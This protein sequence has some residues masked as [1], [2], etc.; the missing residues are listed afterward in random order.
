MRP[1]GVFDGAA[2]TV[3]VLA[4][5]IEFAMLR[6]A[7]VRSQIR[8]Y[9]TQSLLVALLAVIVAAGRAELWWSALVVLFVAVQVFLVPRLV[10]RVAHRDAEIAGRNRIGVV[11]SVLVGIAVAVSGF[12][13]V[14][15]LRVRSTL[16]P[17]ALAMSVGIVL[18][19]FVLVV[20]RRDV[21][22]RVVGFLALG[23]G[24]SLAGLVIAWPLVLGGAS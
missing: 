10:S 12:F 24:V 11:G 19:A 23:N 15:A 5:L 13:A 14:G 1:P 2:D 7:F 9:V 22:S 8:L 20:V 16:P 6:V 21:V 17:T 3:A 18:V 4:L